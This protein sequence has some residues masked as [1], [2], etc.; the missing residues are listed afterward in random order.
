MF[1]IGNLYNSK[2]KATVEVKLG[3]KVLSFTVGTVISP[4]SKEELYSPNQFLLLNEYIKYK[5]DKFAN[6]L[7]QRYEEAEVITMDSIRNKSQYA[8]PTNLA[9]VILD[10][11]DIDDVYNF[12]KHVAKVKA[13]SDLQDY[14]DPQTELDGIGSRVQTYIKEDYLELV[15]LAIIIKAV[16]AP[17]CNYGYVKKEALVSG[18]TEYILLHFLRGHKIFQTAPMVKLLGFVNKIINKPLQTEE[19]ANNVRVFENQIPS[20]ELPYYLLGILIFQK[21]S[22]ATILDDKPGKNIVTIMFNYGNNKIGTKKDTGKT[23]REKK[24]LT[25]NESGNGD[26]ESIF[27]SSRILADYSSGTQIELNMS[28]KDVETIYN[29]LPQT[30]KDLI[31]IQVMKDAVG[32]TR[33]FLTNGVD[34]TQISFIAI[35]FKNIINPRALDY[36]SIEGIVSLQAVGFAL[37]WGMGFK[38]LALYLTS[39]RSDID[40]DSLSINTVVNRNRLPKEIKDELDIIYPHKRVINNETSENVAEDWINTIA[41]K[42][43]NIKWVPEATENY[44]QEGLTNGV[45]LTPNIKIEIGKLILALERIIHTNA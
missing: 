3:D 31:D 38:S 35:M 10:M 22:I 25:D 41:N 28:V 36:I 40:E 29:Q 42:I 27:E 21:L 7:F 43:Y 14:F 26:K 9:H 30:E 44:L 24:A 19:G 34:Q 1:S 12:V 8:L 32:F 45:I 11:F 2:E 4:R 37:L 23:F 16:F 33:P 6:D 15:A 5:G 18:S 20:D 13:P 39:R 17:I